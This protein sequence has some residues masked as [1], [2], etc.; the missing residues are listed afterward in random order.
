MSVQCKYCQH[1]EPRKNPHCYDCNVYYG[2]G[3]KNTKWEKAP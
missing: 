1:Y 3:R 2:D